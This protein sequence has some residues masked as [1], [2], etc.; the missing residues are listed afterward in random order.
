MTIAEFQNW[1]R[2][3]CP[4]DRGVDIYNQEGKVQALKSL[5]A[6][7]ENEFSREQL[8]R[9]M[10]GLVTTSVEA[11]FKKA[12]D[13]VRPKMSDVKKTTDEIGASMKLFAEIDRINKALIH[14]YKDQSNMHSKLKLITNR[15]KRKALAFAIL[16]KGVEIRAL[17]VRKK[18]IEENNTLPPEVKELSLEDIEDRAE[19]KK[20]QLANRVYLSKNRNRAKKLDECA[21][22][23]RENEEIE[24]ILGS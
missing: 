6:L 11:T 15:D 19:L 10:E 8:Y 4:F 23:I 5:F 12:A 18:Y 24:K 3:G 20:K 2:Q 1:K 21:R 17:A 16:D 14:C 22:R 13:G 9:A 7:G